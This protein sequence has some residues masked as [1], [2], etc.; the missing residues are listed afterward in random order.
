[1]AELL[2]LSL[3]KVWEAS[4]VGSLMSCLYQG[5]GGEV[6]RGWC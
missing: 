4:K 1:M 6:G 2:K 3:R 5:E